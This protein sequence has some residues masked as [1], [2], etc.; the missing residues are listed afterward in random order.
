M[1][2]IIATHPATDDPPKIGKERDGLVYELFVSTVPTPAGDPPKI[3]WIFICTGDRLKPYEPLKT[4]S[5]ILT[6]GARTRLV[7]RNFGRSSHNGCGISA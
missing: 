1:R 7:D 4:M 6:D 2:V 5:K 3:C